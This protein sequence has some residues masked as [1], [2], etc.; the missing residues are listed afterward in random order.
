MR[1]IYEKMLLLPQGVITL[2]LRVFITAKFA[3]SDYLKKS[4]WKENCY[5]EVDALKKVT[6]K[7]NLTKT[8]YDSD[9]NFA[10]NGRKR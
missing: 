4:Q 9:W 5:I 3:E 7:F 2:E 1:V 10:H 6:A 8:Y